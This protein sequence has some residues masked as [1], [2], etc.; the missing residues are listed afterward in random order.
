MELWDV[1]DIN[2]NITNK[3]MVRGEAFE[4]DNYHLVVHVCIFN[5]NG[6]MLIQQRQSFKE[7]WPNLWDITA[8][9]SATKGDTSQTAAEREMYEEIGLK[10]DLSNIRPH[11]TINFKNGF[12][13][14]YLVEENVDIDQL[15]L[16]PEEVQ[17]VRWATK[18]EIFTMIDSGEFIPYYPS[19]IQLLFDLRKQ[20]GC[21]Q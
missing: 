13:D 5:T 18:E 1:Y 2:R 4:K 3:T 17:K 11:I 21:I 8:G 9:G 19:L 6:D 20:Y 14:V 12:D 16:Q 7:G 15:T 10:L